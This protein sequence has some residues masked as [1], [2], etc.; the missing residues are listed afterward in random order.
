MVVWRFLSFWD[1]LFSGAILN[2]GCSTFICRTSRWELSVQLLWNF[3]LSD[4]PDSLRASVTQKTDAWN[5]THI[6]IYHQFRQYKTGLNLNLLRL[7][8]YFRYT[9][10]NLRLTCW[11]PHEN[12]WVHI[13]GMKNPTQKSRYSESNTFVKTGAYNTRLFC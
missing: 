3:Q 5:T 11:K 13:V 12:F 1:G 8:S 4:P 2:L 7:L 10:I 6:W 9:V